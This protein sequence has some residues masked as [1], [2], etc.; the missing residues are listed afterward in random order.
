MSW[1]IV[2]SHKKWG[3]IKFFFKKRVL[4]KLKPKASLLIKAYAK[5]KSSL[6]F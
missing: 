5:N 3:Q 6:T 4:R 2:D 1:K